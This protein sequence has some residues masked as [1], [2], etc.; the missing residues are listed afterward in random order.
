VTLRRLAE[1][2][3][4]ALPGGIV[5][6]SRWEQRMSGA[7]GMV[8][9]L[10]LDEAGSLVKSVTPLLGF[11]LTLLAA[12]R[13]TA[14]GGRGAPELLVRTFVRPSRPLPSPRRLARAS[15]RLTVRGGPPP[16]PPSA[17]AQSVELGPEA[18]RVRV[19]AGRRSP[20]TEVDREPFLRASPYLNHRDPPVAALAAAALGGSGASDAAR[21]EALR[22]FV[23]RTVAQ[24][25]LATGFATASEVAR[26]RAGDCTEHAVLLAA[27]LRA[28]GIPSR[29]AAGLLYVEEFAGERQ[30]FGYHMWTQGLVDGAWVDLDA[31]TPE[32]F[33]A[34]HVAL[35]LTALEDGEDLAGAGALLASLMGGLAIEVM[36]AEPEGAGGPAPRRADGEGRNGR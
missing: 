5:V 17:G 6:A 23:H 35:A 8:S 33:D 21:A 4:V 27:L 1:P 2:E 24:K 26:S 34:A 14:R 10:Y 28:A 31:M 25:D 9:T 13:E 15:Y 11:D 30:I 32:P 3:A 29:V 18:A 36:E 7:A 20:A 16:E 22:A 12:D 19:E